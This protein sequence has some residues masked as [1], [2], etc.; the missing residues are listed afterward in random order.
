[1]SEDSTGPIEWVETDRFVMPVIPVELGVD[2]LLLAV[3]HSLAFL[4]IS[5]DQT[6]EPDWAVEAME[7]IAHYLQRLDGLRRDEL[8]GQLGRI[9]DYCEQTDC[10]PRLRDLVRNCFVYAGLTEG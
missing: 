8:N 9:A 2:P 3:L 5:G 10:D 7:H 6:V 1:M 4:E